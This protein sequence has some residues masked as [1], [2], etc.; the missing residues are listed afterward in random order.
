MITEEF[1]NNVE[2]CFE[3]KKDKKEV[4][5]GNVML[6]DFTLFP[7]KPTSKTIIDLGGR[8]VTALISDLNSVKV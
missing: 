7:V 6:L 8:L 4:I 3:S 1:V 5:T 2:C